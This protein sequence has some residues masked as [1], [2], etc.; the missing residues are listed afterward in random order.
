MTKYPNS[1][2]YCNSEGGTYSVNWNEAIPAIG[3]IVV[4]GW[5]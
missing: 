4:N 3:K 2:V 5:I 1:V